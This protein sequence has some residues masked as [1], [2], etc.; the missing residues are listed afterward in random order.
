MTPEDAL[1]ASIKILGGLEATAEA[2]SRPGKTITRQAV[3]Q[4]KRCPLHWRKPLA[5]AVKKA[6]PRIPAE[7]DL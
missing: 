4:W 2:I 5:A 3:G 6:L 1:A 7:A